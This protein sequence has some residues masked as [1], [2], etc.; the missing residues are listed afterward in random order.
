MNSEQHGKEKLTPV[1]FCIV[2]GILTAVISFFAFSS[3]SDPGRHRTSRVNAC[4][5]NLR[6]IDGAKCQW[7]LEHK[8]PSNAIPTWSNIQPYLGRGTGGTLPA[9]PQGGVYTIGPLTEAPTCS[10]KGHTLE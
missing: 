1:E 2:A 3:M 7:A 8:A 5:N 10:I 9:C 6:Q 4:I